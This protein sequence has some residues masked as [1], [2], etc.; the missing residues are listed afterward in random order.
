M[1]KLLAILL[2]LSMLFSLT[3]AMTGCDDSS[4]RRRSSSRRD[5]DDDDDDDRD[6]DDDDDDAA[7]RGDEDVPSDFPAG[8]NSQ[9]SEATEPPVVAPTRP[10]DYVEPF[11]LFAMPI[12]SDDTN[13]SKN[14]VTD[15]YG[16]KYDGPY[17]D[18]CSY[19]YA[20]GS[21]KYIT[22]DATEFNLDGK[23]RYFSGTFFTRDEQSEDY[24]IEFMVYADDTL[25][26]RSEPISRKTKA[27]TF[28]IDIGNCQVL[29]IASRSYDHTNTGTNPGIILVNA[30]VTNEYY[31]ELTESAEIN[32]N[33]IPLTD[34][35]LYGTDSQAGGD[36]I[37]AGGV[38]NAYGA[39][40]K[41][42]YLRLI[43]WGNASGKDYDRQAYCEFVNNG[44]YR[45][46][47]GT[48]FARAD[49]SEDY[50]I[51]FM[52]Y[53]D[54]EL[55]YSSGPMDRGT[56]PIDFVVE[57]GECDLIR[58]QTRTKDYTSVGSNPGVYLFDAFVSAEEP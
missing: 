14:N 9:A 28:T 48:I 20:S 22:E 25:I 27:I 19:G 44:Q 43:S 41:G 29:R 18:L 11:A 42:I 5:R 1:K 26:F 45:Y 40:Y 2:I 58:V 6:D 16:N 36:N 55:V 49:Q 15:S 39:L 17:F 56:K 24:T 8:E 21:G 10:S 46:L 34:L 50:T 32:H 52:V 31:G 7:G 37:S 35:H 57:I 12:I 51:E 23:Y 33:L 30:M 47:C 53:A 4:D 38:E 3:I 54:D 13:L